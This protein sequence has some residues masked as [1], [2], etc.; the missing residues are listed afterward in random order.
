MKHLNKTQK[1]KQ[2]FGPWQM[3]FPMSVC[4]HWK[5]VKE[6]FR[7]VTVMLKLHLAKVFVKVI[8]KVIA[9]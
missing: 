9:V 8:V 4:Q 1:I 5:H 2:K 6:F 3:L 7:N